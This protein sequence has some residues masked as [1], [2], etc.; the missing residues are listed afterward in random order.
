VVVVVA[1]IAAATLLLAGCS[2]HGSGKAIEAYVEPGDNALERVRDAAPHVTTLGVDGVTIAD[3][4]TALNTVPSGLRALVDAAHEGGAK[5]ELLVSN[6]S[7]SVYDFS[8]RVATALLRSDEHRAEVATELAAAAARIGADGVQIDLESLRE[9]DVDGLAAFAGSVSD[10]VH[11]R[12]GRDATVSMAVMASERRGEY[13]ERGYDLAALAQHVDRFVL[14]TY[15]QHG[16]WSGPGTIGSLPWAERA[17]RAAIAEGAPT[18]RVDLGVAGYGYA[19][20]SKPGDPPLTPERARS[21]AGD[22]A[23]WSATTG[24]WHAALADGREL[25]WMDDRS[26]RVRRDLAVRLGLHGTAMWSLN[27]SPLD[28]SDENTTKT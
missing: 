25:H 14:M 3:D 6:Y 2:A 20:P 16:P 22:A 24:E 26:F 18:E 5:V 19:W 9:R 23:T 12:I 28:L 1:G 13:R 21:L 7:E 8:P 11:E 27:L 4:G 17:V 10:A 15:D